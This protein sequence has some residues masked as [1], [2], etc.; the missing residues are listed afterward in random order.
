MPGDT[1][2]HTIWL[3]VVPLGTLTA[4]GHFL[5]LTASVSLI[6]QKS[7]PGPEEVRDKKGQWRRWR[8][9]KGWGQRWPRQAQLL[10]ALLFQPMWS[11]IGKFFKLFPFVSRG[12]TEEGPH[13]WQWPCGP[14]GGSPEDR[15]LKL[16][17]PKARSHRETKRRPWVQGQGLHAL[18][19]MRCFLTGYKIH[20]VA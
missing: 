6:V 12:P 8:D 11:F 17:L 9:P 15:A 13:H 19:E 7:A 20:Q 4:I 10:W 18:W 16:A 3:W 14:V 5:S 2:S 1:D